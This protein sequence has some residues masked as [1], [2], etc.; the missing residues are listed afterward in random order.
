M[1]QRVSDI[2]VLCVTVGIWHAEGMGEVTVV[3]ANGS[4]ETFVI[5]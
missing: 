2:S 4:E 1:K 3:N 5:Q